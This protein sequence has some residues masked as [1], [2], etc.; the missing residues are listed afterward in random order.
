VTLVQQTT[1]SNAGAINETASLDVGSVFDEFVR[2]QR[3][4]LFVDTVL[5]VVVDGAKMSMRIFAVTS[6]NRNRQQQ[7]SLFLLALH[8]HTTHIEQA[9]M[10]LCLCVVHAR[11][12]CSTILIPRGSNFCLSPLSVKRRM[13]Q[14]NP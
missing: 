5:P 14:E 2:W 13:K 10:L 11:K 4:P 3:W 1:Q 12:T 7:M 8:T 6:Q 9:M